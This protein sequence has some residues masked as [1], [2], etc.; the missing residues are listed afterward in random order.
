MGVL[1]LDLD[2]FKHINDTLG[3]ETGDTLLCMVAARL[4]DTVR[5]EDTVARL[6]GDEFVIVLWDLNL[7][8]DVSS[9]LTKLL[10]TLSQPYVIK[11]HNVNVTLS[12]GASI[13]PMHGDN[14][15]T[16]LKSADLAMYEAKRD[17]KNN[18]HL[19]VNT[20]PPKVRT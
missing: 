18:F 12:I 17:G 10:A 7:D 19:A 20:R 8:N 13:Y 16:L 9:L 4:V 5:Q 2:G 11:G 14:A 3:H 6:G 1:Y 15:E